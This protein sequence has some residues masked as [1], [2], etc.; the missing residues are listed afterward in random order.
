MEAEVHSRRADPSKVV[1]GQMETPEEDGT[2][3]ADSMAVI[4][5]W[6]RRICLMEIQKSRANRIV[7]CVKNLTH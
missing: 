2:K 6:L 4:D 7:Y 5:Y 1:P 3:M